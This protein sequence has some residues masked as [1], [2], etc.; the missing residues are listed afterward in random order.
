MTYARLTGVYGLSF[1]EING[2]PL[3]A[4]E[5]YLVNVPRVLAERKLVTGEGAVL[6][7]MKDPRKQL[8]R[9]QRLAYPSQPRAAPATPGMLRSLGIGVRIV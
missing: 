9:W 8:K 2:M 5:A 4:I 7:W 1:Q 6:P 3:A